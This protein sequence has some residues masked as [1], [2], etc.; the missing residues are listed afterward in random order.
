MWLISLNCSYVYPYLIYRNHVWGLACKTYMNKLFL[1][2]KGIIW[3]IAGVNRRPHTDPIFKDLK[4]LKCN[5]INTYLIG[6]LMHRIYKGD[7]IL[8]QSYFKKNKEIHRYVTRQINHYHVPSVRTELGKS[9]LHCHGVFIWNT[10]LN[11]GMDPVMTEYEFSK[12][13]KKIPTTTYTVI[14]QQRILF[15]WWINLLKWQV[16]EVYLT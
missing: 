10:I 16:V 5:D 2:Q 6:R 3:I 4:L 9:A 12:S 1:L 8:V 11:L 14:L 7:I 15:N 13:L